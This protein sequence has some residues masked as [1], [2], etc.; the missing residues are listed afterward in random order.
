M[1]IIIIF[2]IPTRI[3]T[4]SHRPYHQS[5]GWI[6][7]RPAD[8]LRRESLYGETAAI[9]LLFVSRTESGYFYI[10]VFTWVPPP[11]TYYNAV[12]CS[13]YI[14]NMMHIKQLDLSTSPKPSKFIILNNISRQMFSSIIQKIDYGWQVQHNVAALLLFKFGY[15]LRKRCKFIKKLPSIGSIKQF[16]KQQVCVRIQFKI[17][18]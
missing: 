3:L 16:E 12:A 6:V 13:Y 7:C 10:A 8:K 1:N 4:I 9:L 17:V 11:R 15:I 18:D 2:S 5:A 14:N